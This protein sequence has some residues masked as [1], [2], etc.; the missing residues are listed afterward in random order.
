MRTL[1]FL[2]LASILTLPAHAQFASDRDA[3]SA[4]GT[5][6]VSVDDAAK[7]YLN[8]KEVHNASVGE[9]RSAEIELKTGDRVVAHL[10]N[11]SSNRQF[12]IFFA[13][14]DGQ[15]IVSF[16]NRD[17]KIVPDLDVTDFTPDQFKAWNKYSKDLKR[18]DVFPIK[19]YSEWVWGD[20]DKCI[21]ACTVTPNMFSKRPH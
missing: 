14:T 1:L 18:K 21:L 16:R 4:K 9:S 12:M 13:S 17:F 6:Y 7:I 3:K 2:L 10:R 15:S 19:N 5:F 8:G 20:L 11:D